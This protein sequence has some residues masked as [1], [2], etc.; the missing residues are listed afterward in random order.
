[1]KR[2]IALIVTLSVI[3]LAF[4]IHTPVSKSASKLRSDWPVYG[5]DSE[6]NH[7]SPLNQINKSNVSKLQVAWT[8]DSGEAGGIETSPIIVGN[9]LYTYTPK[10]AVVALDAA[11]GKVLLE[12]RCRLVRRPGPSSG[13]LLVRRKRQPH[14]RRR[15]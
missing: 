1:M 12:I 4:L 8:Y 5:G 11:T 2:R 13:H 15:P 10:N 7:Y 6:D 3:I 14:P 9:V